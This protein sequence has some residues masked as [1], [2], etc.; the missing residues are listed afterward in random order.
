M[1]HR[2]TLPT[3]LFLAI[4]SLASPTSGAPATPTAAATLDDCAGPVGAQGREEGISIGQPYVWALEDAHYLLTRIHDRSHTLEALLPKSSDLDPRAIHQRRLELVRSL[5][6]ASVQF[7]AT[8]GL[9]NEL[10]LDTYRSETSQLS[11][12]RQRRAVAE[13]RLLDVTREITELEVLRAELYS[14]N[15]QSATDAAGQGSSP[16]A[17]LLRPAGAASKAELDSKIASL[18]AE[19]AVLKEQIASITTQIGELSTSAPDLKVP[20]VSAATSPP[21]DV[22]AELLKTAFAATSQPALPGNL[23]L[24]N[25]LQLQYEILARQITL[26]RNEISPDERLL[27]LELPH[28]VALRPERSLW[29]RLFSSW[30]RDV[31]RVEW[32]ITGYCAD[33]DATADLS[34]FFDQPTSSTRCTCK[35]LIQNDRRVRAIELI[36]RHQT[37]NSAELDGRISGLDLSASASATSGVGAQAGYSRQKEALD[38]LV[39][40]QVLTTSFGRG[41]A[42]FGWLFGL[43]PAR[44]DLL[45]DKTTYAVLVVPKEARALQLEAYGAFNSRRD[46]HKAATDSSPALTL[47]LELPPTSWR[48][49]FIREVSYSSVPPGDV[50]T[51]FL[52]GSGFPPQTSVLVNGVPLRRAQSIGDAGLT[53]VKDVDGSFEVIGSQTIV[54]SFRMKPDYVGTPIISLVSPGKTVPINYFKNMRINGDSGTESLMDYAQHHPMFSPAPGL[55]GLYLTSRIESCPR[56][57]CL[58]EAI[59]EGRGFRRGARVFVNGQSVRS[60][61]LSPSRLKLWLT[62]E[63]S[64]TWRVSYFDTST[65]RPLEAVADLANPFA[66]HV[67]SATITSPDDKPPFLVVVRGRQL[68]GAKFFPPGA[69]LELGGCWSTPNPP[70]GPVPPKRDCIL[71]R[72]DE[73]VEIQLVAKPQPP[74]LRASSRYENGAEVTGLVALGKPA[75]PPP[76]PPAIL[77]LTSDVTGGASAPVGK[78]FVLTIHGLNL[79][80]VNEVT[81][82]NGKCEILAASPTVLQV[83]VPALPV[84]PGP[85]RVNLRQNTSNGTR[86]NAADLSTA[87]FYFTEQPKQ[88]R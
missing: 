9:E 68:T 79:K 57:V 61:Y 83:K 1:L 8:L 14:A 74:Q 45:G 49:F 33:T 67:T 58:R 26:L 16:G 38:E 39:G 30:S 40:R 25:Y 85:F 17:S 12:L 82:G 7:D 52:R 4:S 37:L 69:H 46:A 63:G 35:T 22:V 34:Q 70:P 60:S 53:A 86:H 65:Q 41:T 21:G 42:R 84:A 71:S 6:S 77:F 23:V 51:V 15:E 80:D 19:Q 64:I 32:R 72:S 18:R 20:E 11:N 28:S 29:Y 2:R 78:S 47:Q 56:S 43:H 3:F 10:A 31:A 44:R 24:D 66:P 36:P 48:R 27:F 50:A 73:L 76:Q 88:A 81:L 5:L 13:S 62:P 55:A 54:L 75:T 59:L 87:I